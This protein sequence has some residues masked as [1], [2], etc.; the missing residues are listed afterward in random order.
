M[1]DFENNFTVK[2]KF[3]SRSNIALVFIILLA[4][5]IGI[6]VALIA[7]FYSNQQK[8]DRIQYPSI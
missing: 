7:M 6:I 4:I 5:V 1:Q 3:F 8:T 2:K